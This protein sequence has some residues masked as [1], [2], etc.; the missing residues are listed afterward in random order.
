MSIIDNRLKMLELKSISKHKVESSNFNPKGKWDFTDIS[1]N[2][3]PIS[4]SSNNSTGYSTKNYKS[5]GRDWI[6][7]NDINTLLN[8]SNQWSCI[9]TSGKFA[10]SG[11]YDGN[12][13]YSQDYGE[14]WVDTGYNNKWTD[15]CISNDGQTMFVVSEIGNVIYSFDAGINWNTQDSYINEDVNFFYMC[16]YS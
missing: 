8:S 7:S 13:F 9:A 10:V 6:Q 12:V 15:C 4:S 1:C 2:G 14:S 3:I 5:Y 11:I 16:N